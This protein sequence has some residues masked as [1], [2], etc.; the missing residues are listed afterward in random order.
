MIGDFQVNGDNVVV[1]EGLGVK[2][3]RSLL[4][5]LVLST[6]WPMIASNLDYR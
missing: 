2:Q 4:Y 1:V 5:R 3:C 6:G